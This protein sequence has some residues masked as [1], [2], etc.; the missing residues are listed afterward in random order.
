MMEAITIDSLARW[1]APCLAA[2]MGCYWFWKNRSK[3]SDEIDK[4]VI[5]SDENQKET[6]MDNIYSNLNNQQLLERVL[7]N[8]GCHINLCAEKD[9]EFNVTYQG[10]H[11]TIVYSEDSS[12]ITIYDIAWY[13]EELNDID[14]FS[15]VTKA[16][17]LCNQRNTSTVLYTIDKDKNCVNVHTRQCVVF[18]SFI[19]K[20]EDYLRSRFE[21][22]FLQ[23]HN[24][25]RCME[26]SRKEQFV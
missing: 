24:F 8:I 21:D 5:S 11:F 26:L 14:N 16:V 7:K 15:M 17:N 6:I 3:E 10:E 20:L 13:S 1:F 22:S 2:A 19:P 25:Y 18:G 12:Y 23:H 4:P 9:C